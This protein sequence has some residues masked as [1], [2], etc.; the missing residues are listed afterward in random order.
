LSRHFDS[1][2][3]VIVPTISAGMREKA[4]SESM[5]GGS[6]F[7]RHAPKRIAAEPIQI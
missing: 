1:A 2:S 4:N 5:S 6:M 3:Q 7:R